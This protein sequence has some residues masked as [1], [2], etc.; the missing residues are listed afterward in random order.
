M[1]N[2]SNIPGMPEFIGPMRKVWNF[3]KSVM[4]KQ[5]D[6]RTITGGNKRRFSAQIYRQDFDFEINNLDAPV[7]ITAG[8]TKQIILKDDADHNVF[9][10]IIREY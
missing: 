6:E 3:N 10:T 9:P 2:L 8:S 5:F 4:N 1:E 7:N